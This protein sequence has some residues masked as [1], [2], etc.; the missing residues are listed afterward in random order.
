MEWGDAPAERLEPPGPRRPRPKGACSAL[1]LPL[2]LRKIGAGFPV[3]KAMAAT[4][5]LRSF[6]SAASWSSYVAVTGIFKRSKSRAAVIAV[7]AS[8]KCDPPMGVDEPSAGRRER[9]A[10]RRP[11]ARRGGGKTEADG[12]KEPYFSV[13]YDRSSRTGCGAIK[14]SFPADT[15]SKPCP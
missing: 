5:P 6:S 13:A 7:P 10:D 11:R 3:T 4:S 12:Q 15:S 9:H 1:P 14:N 8:R 2:R